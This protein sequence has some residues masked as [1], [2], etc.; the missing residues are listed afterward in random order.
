MIVK[1]IV[2]ETNKFL[3][4]SQTENHSK[5]YVFFVVVDVMHKGKQR[6]HL[7]KIENKV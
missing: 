6:K 5:L 2:T 1:T 7:G 4:K 3:V